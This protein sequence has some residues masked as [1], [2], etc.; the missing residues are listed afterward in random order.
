MP[1]RAD[2][3]TS[4]DPFGVGRG[5]MVPVQLLSKSSDAL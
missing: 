2:C 5:S 1:S 3:D 4:G